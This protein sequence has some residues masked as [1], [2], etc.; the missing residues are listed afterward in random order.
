MTKMG[1]ADIHVNLKRLIETINTSAGRSSGSSGA[2][3][4]S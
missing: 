4:G 3:R 1:T 2:G